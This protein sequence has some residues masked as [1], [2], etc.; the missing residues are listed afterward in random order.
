MLQAAVS[1]RMVVLFRLRVNAVGYEI[2]TISDSTAT[3]RSIP[4]DGQGLRYTAD[5]G[6]SVAG[7]CSAPRVARLA[8]ERPKCPTSR[9]KPH[10]GS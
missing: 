8:D 10:H 7:A 5:G 4:D 9:D 1:V 2:C 6:R 3:L